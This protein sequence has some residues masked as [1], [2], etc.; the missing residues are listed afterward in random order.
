MAYAKG[1]TVSVERSRLE[2]ERVLKRYGA[3]K[4]TVGWNEDAEAIAFHAHNRRVRFTVRIPTESEFI[5][6]DKGRKRTP[7]AAQIALLMENRRRWR[8]LGLVIKS[9]LEAVESGISSFEEEFLAHILLPNGEVV[10]NWLIPQIADSYANKKMPP[11]MGA[12]HR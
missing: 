2:I 1:T 10:G 7:K 4:F 8:A 12:A 9:K 3:T 5:E 11:L 6:T